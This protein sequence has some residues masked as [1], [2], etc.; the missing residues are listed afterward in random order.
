M[1]LVDLGGLLAD[2]RKHIGGATKQR[3]FPTAVHRLMN[4]KAARQLCDRLLTL[5]RLKHDRLF[6]LG[7]VFFLFLHL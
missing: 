5:E 1:P 3:L 2:K 7:C 4:T 6:E